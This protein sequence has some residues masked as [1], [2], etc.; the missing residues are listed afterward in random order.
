MSL[1]FSSDGTGAFQR[2]A[3]S[4]RRFAV[5]RPL[6]VYY[7]VEKCTKFI[8]SDPSFTKVFI[9]RYIISVNV[10]LIDLGW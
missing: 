3:D 10:G 8:Q 7:E 6:K 1:L 4:P 2:Q 9:F 5:E